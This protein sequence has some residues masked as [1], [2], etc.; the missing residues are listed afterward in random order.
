MS[1]AVFNESHRVC[2]VTL[3]G[4][5]PGVGVAAEDG[6][7]VSILLLI[8]LEYSSQELTLQGRISFLNS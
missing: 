2:E 1:K 7:V 6:G 3:E 8:R 5:S 4:A